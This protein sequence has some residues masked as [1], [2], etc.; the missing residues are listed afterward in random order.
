[1]IRFGDEHLSFIVRPLPGGDGYTW[2]LTTLLSSFLQAAESLYGARDKTWTPVGVEFGEK[3]PMIWYPGNRR[4]VAIML[5]LSAVENAAQAAF[6]LAH[7]T[8]HLLSPTGRRGDA[9]VL[10]EGIASAFADKMAAECGSPFRTG[11]PEYVGALK[12]V[13]QFL[14]LY[15]DGVR[16]LRERE[17]SFS[18]ITP[19]SFAETCP[20]VTA[21]LAADLCRRWQSGGNLT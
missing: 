9:P 15:P 11:A 4:H 10:E 19:E 1:M 17:P 6:Q 14:A 18:K 7:E 2:S 3:G 20:N 21:G 13:E 16:M 12:L 8:I 5:G